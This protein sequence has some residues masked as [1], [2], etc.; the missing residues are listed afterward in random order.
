M[1][2]LD[3]SSKPSQ[4]RVPALLSKTLSLNLVFKATIIKAIMLWHCGQYIR[5]ICQ[6]ETINW[7]ILVILSCLV[8]PCHSTQFKQTKISSHSATA[9]CTLVVLSLILRGCNI[10]A[11]CTIVSRIK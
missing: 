1:L 10:R 4:E 2:L 5:I 11:S 3:C 9:L 7:S 8:L 6:S